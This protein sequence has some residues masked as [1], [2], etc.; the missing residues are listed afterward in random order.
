MKGGRGRELSKVESRCAKS[1][2]RC[3]KANVEKGLRKQVVRWG[4]E[5]KSMS[6]TVYHPA[7]EV[8]D[9]VS[10]S[11]LPPPPLCCLREQQG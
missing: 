3:G 1:I 11:C 4:P 7:E 9:R 5:L 8:T 10:S 6:T 2:G